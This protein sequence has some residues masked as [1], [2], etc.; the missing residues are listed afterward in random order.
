MT[1]IFWLLATIL[2][3]FFL[4]HAAPADSTDRF[5]TSIGV[6][7]LPASG[8]G[9]RQ[10]CESSVILRGKTS[11]LSI[12]TRRE[13]RT[14]SQASWPNSCNSRLMC[15][16]FQFFHRSAQLNRQPRRSPLSW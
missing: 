13:S 4:A 8:R 15:F 9:I 12:A 2:Q 14:V 11:W 6:P 16:L 7:T 5:V 1:K 10:G 3:H